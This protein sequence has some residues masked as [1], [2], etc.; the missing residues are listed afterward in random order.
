[1]SFNVYLHGLWVW[2]NDILYFLLYACKIQK[3]FSNI[4]V[5]FFFLFI[6]CR[7]VLCDEKNVR[8][9]GV[10]FL[11]FR[12]AWGGK[13]IGNLLVK[14]FIFSCNMSNNHNAVCSNN[15]VRTCILSMIDSEVSFW[16]VPGI[17]SVTLEEN[18]FF[19]LQPRRS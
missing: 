13:Y 1:M 17:Q 12:L 9:S 7:Y 19:V 6:L 16:A 11:S 18:I 3:A 8:V 4:H 10:L 5:F 2:E 15:L 14:L